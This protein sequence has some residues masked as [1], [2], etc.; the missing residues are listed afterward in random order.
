M[1]SRS[2][3][4]ANTFEPKPKTNLVHHT[5]DITLLFDVVGCDGL[6][7]LQDFARVDEL[8][9]FGLPSFLG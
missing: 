9:Q 8:L 1:A 2:V 4:L 7:I 6:V 5:H 3:G